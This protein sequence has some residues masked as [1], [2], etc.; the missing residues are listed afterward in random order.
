MDAICNLISS[1]LSKMVMN[2]GH[3]VDYSMR[4]FRCIKL[5]KKYF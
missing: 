2:E 1:T 3:L 5:F 4:I